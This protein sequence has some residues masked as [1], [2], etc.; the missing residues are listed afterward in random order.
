MFDLHPSSPPPGGT[1]V[2]V[3]SIVS[4]VVDPYRLLVFIPLDRHESNGI[5]RP[6]EE[7]R[8]AGH[9]ERLERRP[10]DELPAAR[11][12]GRIDA[13]LRTRNADGPARHTNAAASRFVDRG[14]P[15][16]QSRA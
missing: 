7:R 8:V 11:R 6:E 1:E 2:G 5:A 3:V 10:P 15:C 16:R 9:I 4:F 14:H 12:L 13:G